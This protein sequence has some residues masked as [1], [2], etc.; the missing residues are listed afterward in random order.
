MRKNSKE[1]NSVQTSFVIITGSK[2]KQNRR[3]YFD[4]WDNLNH[5]SA[6]VT[7]LAISTNRNR[8]RAEQGSNSAVNLDGT[9]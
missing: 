4:V 5:S 2:K 9:F 3:T 1:S 6:A 7:L 8:K